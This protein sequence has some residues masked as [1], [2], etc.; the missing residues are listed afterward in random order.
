MFGRHESLL[1]FPSCMYIL[2]DT[3]FFFCFSLLG[4]GVFDWTVVCCYGLNVYILSGEN[5][6][7]EVGLIMSN[8]SVRSMCDRV[9]TGSTWGFILVLVIAMWWALMVF[10]F[11]FCVLLGFVPVDGVFRLA[12]RSARNRSVQLT[13]LGLGSKEKGKKDI[14]AST[15][16]MS[17][18]VPFTIMS[19]VIVRH[20]TYHPASHNVDESRAEKWNLFR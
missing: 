14:I 18:S 7:R 5:Q 11:C 16:L 20:T 6:K 10:F 19:D 3:F 12:R 17:S 15:F 1:A 2:L 13:G 4:S 9:E 8:K